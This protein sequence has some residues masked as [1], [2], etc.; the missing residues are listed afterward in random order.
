MKK[1]NLLLLSFLISI[2]FLSCSKKEEETKFYGNIDLRTVSLGHRVSGKIKNIYFDE[3]QFVK[4]DD[5]LVELEDDIYQQAL[6]AIESQIKVQE[7][8]ILKLKKGYRPEEIKKAKASY[9]KS[10]IELEK[11][12]KEYERFKKLYD[13]K[14][15]SKQT[16]EDYKFTYQGA[17]AQVDYTK[18]ALNELENGYQS[19]DIMMAEGTLES[20]KAQ[21]NQAK[22]SL[23][24][25][26]LYA[27]ND[28]IILTR[29]YEVGAIV[30]KGTPIID[31]AITNEYWIRSYIEEK[32]L[33]LIKP[34]M[35]AIVKTDSSDKKYTA[36]VSFISAQAEFTPKSVQT[37]ELRTQLVYRIRLIIENP[38]ENIRQGMPVTIEFEDLK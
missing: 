23:Q 14:S 4:K 36:R 25:T 18:S 31:L 35:K 27:P 1:I 11:S 17:K 28:G 16:F 20:L 10:L 9:E 24:D 33:G 13:T 22:I 32:Y 30:D 21:E 19:E 3:G 38:D 26:K 8:N 34:N 5:L 2:T 6:K 7:A 15:I 37:Q 29:A 12:K